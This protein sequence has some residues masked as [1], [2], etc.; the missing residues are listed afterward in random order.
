MEG[1]DDRSEDLREDEMVEFE[2]D[3]Q[4]REGDE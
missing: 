3:R 2:P 4:M 1:E